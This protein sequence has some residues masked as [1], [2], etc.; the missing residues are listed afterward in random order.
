MQRSAV[1][2]N[3]PQPTDRAGFLEVLRTR[4]S[5]SWL[6]LEAAQAAVLQFGA[7]GYLTGSEVARRLREA[8]FVALVTPPV[9]HIT[10]ELAKG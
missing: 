7:R 1:L 9:K 6:A 4:L 3:E 2:A 5:V 8:Q 10:A